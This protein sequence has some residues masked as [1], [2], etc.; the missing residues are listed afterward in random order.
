MTSQGGPPSQRQS[1]QHDKENALRFPLAIGKV[2]LFKVSRR[3]TQQRFERAT[4]WGPRKRKHERP[5]SER[6]WEPSRIECSSREALTTLVAT[7]AAGAA[8]TAEVVAEGT[9]AVVTGYGSGCD[10]VLLFAKY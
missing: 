8:A 2:K 6:P 10:R 5:S 3:T 4:A 1:T 7:L 9:A